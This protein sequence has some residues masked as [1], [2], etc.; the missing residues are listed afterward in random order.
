M[1]TAEN[2]AADVS[3]VL[4]ADRLAIE[5][6]VIEHA[7]QALA[8]CDDETVA[9]FAPRVWAYLDEADKQ[10][11]RALQA[12]YVMNRDELD[13]LDRSLGWIAPAAR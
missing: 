5:P 7:D 4:L 2:V 9:L 6:F 13:E 11:P 1:D 8:R 3:T 12:R 10:S